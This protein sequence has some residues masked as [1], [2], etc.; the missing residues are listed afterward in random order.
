MLLLHCAMHSTNRVI[1]NRRSLRN[2]CQITQYSLLPKTKL[3]CTKLLLCW[4]SW[5]PKKFG[6]KLLCKLMWHRQMPWK[7]LLRRFTQFSVC[8]VFALE[9]Q[10]D[11]ER[12]PTLAQKVSDSQLE[13]ACFSYALKALLYVVTPAANPLHGTV[14]LCHESSRG[15]LEVKQS[16]SFLSQK[17]LASGSLRW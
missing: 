4:A 3:A 16:H 8:S 9:R 14:L 7:N 10:L 11:A 13:W 17:T 2:L 12:M 6:G 5:R 1:Q 15:K